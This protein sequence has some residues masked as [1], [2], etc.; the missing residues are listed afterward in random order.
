MPRTDVKFAPRFESQRHRDSDSAKC[1]QAT[2]NL[3]IIRL[4]AKYAI[5][6]LTNYRRHSGDQS[7]LTVK[8]STEATTA[9]II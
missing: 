6:S 4:Q 8:Y 5:R 7:D 3:V 1:T 2:F 9:I